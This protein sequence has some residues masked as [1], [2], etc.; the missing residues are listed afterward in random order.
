MKWRIID[1]RTAIPP[2]KG[3]YRSW[4]PQLAAEAALQCVYCCIHESRFGGIRNFHVEHF[5]PQSKFHTLKNEYSNL[6]YACGVCNSF[7]SDDWPGDLAVGD[8]SKPGYPCPAEVDYSNF[9][10]VDERTGEVH[11]DDVTGRYLVERLHLNR[12]HVVA[13][14]AITALL[15]RIKNFQAKID[16][17]VERDEIPDHLKTEVITMMSRYSTL[18]RTYAS[19][20][21][22]GPDQLRAEARAN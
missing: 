14:R 1:K 15:E 4:K 13:L 22:Y 7:K 5:K 16:A 11:G 8:L 18:L 21:P 17:M 9:L 6:F 3:D 2:V 10:H 19:A 12:A 20:R